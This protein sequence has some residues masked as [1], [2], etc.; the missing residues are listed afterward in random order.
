M[1]RINIV[2]LGG[3]LCGILLFGCEREHVE[4]P[5]SS[6]TNVQTFQVYNEFSLASSVE[7]GDREDETLEVSINGSEVIALLEAEI[8][9]DFTDESD[10]FYQFYRIYRIE[11]SPAFGGQAF[12]GVSL[13]VDRAQEDVVEII[14]DINSFTHARNEAGEVIV[15]SSAFASYH[16]SLSDEDRS[17]LEY[18]FE[19]YSFSIDYRNG[20]A[21][22][23][24]FE[25]DDA[26]EIF[27]EELED[28]SIIL[29]GTQDVDSSE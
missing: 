12:L 14:V 13:L 24:F 5:S 22:R 25:G 23:V 28:I 18:S 15:E 19:D 26:E 9:D 29:R 4:T 10:D 20:S 17:R 11:E 21:R 27:A 16:L 7:E 2:L 8:M 3:L 1:K 6:V